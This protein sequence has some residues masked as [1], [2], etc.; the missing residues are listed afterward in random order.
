MKIAI[1]YQ[2]MLGVLILEHCTYGNEIKLVKPDVE[3]TPPAGLACDSF[4]FTH[5]GDKIVCAGKHIDDKTGWIGVWEIKTAKLVKSINVPIRINQISISKDDQYCWMSASDGLFRRI[6]LADKKVIGDFSYAFDDK[7]PIYDFVWDEKRNRL[8]SGL[9]G[10]TDPR[11]WD[12]E[13][14]KPWPLHKYDA[15]SLHPGETVNK[16]CLSQNKAVLGIAYSGPIAEMWNMDKNKRISQV[17]LPKS[18][19]MQGVFLSLDINHDGTLAVFTAL[20]STLNFELIV[21]DI[22][23]SKVVR[24]IPYL[25]NR[26]GY[27]DNVKLISQDKYVMSSFNGDDDVAGIIKIW[28]VNSGKLVTEFLTSESNSASAMNVSVDSKWIASLQTKDSKI[29]LWRVTSIIPK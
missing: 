23:Q 9:F 2:I 19:V 17:T 14:T 1:L 15:E 29:K 13:T 6:S 12:L 8:I 26:R 27:L 5:D 7:Q 20:L 3:L 10:K 16:L 24:R 11:V 21:Y 22:T 4:V 18:P 28:D 25:A